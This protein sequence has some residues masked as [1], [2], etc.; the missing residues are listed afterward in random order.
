MLESHD[1]YNDVG[2]GESVTNRIVELVRS[3][4][5][6]QGI[7]G[8]RISGGGSGGTVAMMVTSDEG[9]HVMMRIKSMVE[10]ETGKLL[11]LFEGSSDG[12][13]YQF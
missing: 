12:A 7:A 3:L 6:G 4:G 13:H 5:L 9:Y 2:L 11:K 8:A 10:D 1:G